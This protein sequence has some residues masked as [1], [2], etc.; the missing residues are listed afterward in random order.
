MRKMSRF[1]CAV[2]VKRDGKWKIIESDQ[3]VPGDIIDSL[4]NGEDENG[5][6]SSLAALPCDCIMLE[7]DAIVNESMLTGESVPVVK[8]GTNTKIMR[9]V[10]CNG[11]DL[12]SMEKHLLSGGTKLI[13][14]RPGE[15]DLTSPQDED[16]STI[17]SAATRSLVVKTGF[18]TA[19]GSLIRS[20]LFPKPVDQK[21]Y[22]DAF[23]FILILVVIAVVGFMGALVYFLKIGV[24]DEEIALRALGE[25]ST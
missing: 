11:K 8:S 1:V 12:K 17:Q 18:N 10:L 14:V 19:K 25:R 13:R 3:L 6:A 4:S 9:E 7:G 15:E 21:F 16:Q 20:M 5:E 24:D 22:A 2:K 23:K